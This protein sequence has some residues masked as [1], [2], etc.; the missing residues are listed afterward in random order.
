M[1]SLVVQSMSSHPFLL[2][3][4]TSIYQEFDA[5]DKVA[6]GFVVEYVFNS[7]I[8]HFVIKYYP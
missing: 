7:I 4:D 5:D 8:I 6:I 1:L 3:S 2:L